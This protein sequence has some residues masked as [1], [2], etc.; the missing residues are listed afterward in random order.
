MDISIVIT[1][2]NYSNYIVDCINSCINQE[3]HNLDYQIIVV[4]DGSS[5]RTKDLLSNI[6]HDSLTSYFIQNSGVE[7]ASNFG[8]N[9][10]IGKYIVRL[11]ADDQ[12]NNSF[13]RDI[14][15][16]LDDKYGFIYGDYLTINDCNEVIDRVSLPDFDK[17]EILNRGDFLATGTLYPRKIIS[18]FNGYREDK[19]NFG[20]ENYDLILKLILS[21]FKGLHISKPLFLY[22]RHDKNLSKIKTSQIIQNGQDLFDE[23]N[24]GKY[25]I[26]KNH[27]YM[28]NTQ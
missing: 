4:D 7:I 25:N 17:R 3:E 9:Q 28:N 15:P 2:Y 11:D 21:G 8:F 23:L 12:L 18:K 26:N 10:S 24:I 22:R 1:S 5:D 13:L 16:F 6:Q 20:L 27:P 14:S 19:K